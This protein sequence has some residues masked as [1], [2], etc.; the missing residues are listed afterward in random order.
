MEATNNLGLELSNAV[1]N[2]VILQL[3]FMQCGTRSM[4]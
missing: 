4:N 2:L 3:C 1:D